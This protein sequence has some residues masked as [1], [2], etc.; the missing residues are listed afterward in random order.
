NELRQELGDGAIGLE[1]TGGHEIYTAH[2][3]QYTSVREGFDRLNDE[4][5][6]IL[7][8][9][10]FEWAPELIGKFGL[11]RVIDLVRSPLEAPIDSGKL[12]MALLRKAISEGVLFRS[13]FE[14]VSLEEKPDHVEIRSS[15]GEQVLAG[16]VVMAMNG[17]TRSLLPDADVIP[18]RGQVLLT[19]PV[20]GPRPIGT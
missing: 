15:E 2:N 11:K 18:G 6:S 1:P 8:D 19:S 16:Q 10:A 13:N 14:V 4:L 7:G 3:E 12:M 9:R 5:R 17:Y 20:E